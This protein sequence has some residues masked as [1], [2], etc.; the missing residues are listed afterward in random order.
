[1]PLYISSSHFLND[2]EQN[3][4]RDP[5]GGPTPN[6]IPEVVVDDGGKAAKSGGSSSVPKGSSRVESSPSGAGGT[7]ATEKVSEGQATLPPVDEADT[8]EVNLS[9]VKL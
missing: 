9:E 1:M 3:E 5:D 7:Q 8:P 2:N 4:D 6:V